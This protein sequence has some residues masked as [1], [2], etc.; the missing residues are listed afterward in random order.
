MKLVRYFTRIPKKIPEGCVAF[1]NFRP[2]HPERKPEENGF[3]LYFGRLEAGEKLGPPCDCGW[4]WKGG[5][6][7][8]EPS[9]IRNKVKYKPPPKADPKIRHTAYR[10]LHNLLLHNHTEYTSAAIEEE[11]GDDGGWLVRVSLVEPPQWADEYFDDFSSSYHCRLEISLGAA[12]ACVRTK[13]L[14]RSREVDHEQE[15]VSYKK[16]FK[17][18]PA[19]LR[20]QT[21]LTYPEKDVDPLAAT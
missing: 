16:L 13:V 2:G 9:G 15:E 14:K 8:Y 17:S 21:E 18:L 19:I 1:H 20:R 6:E 4:S 12:G 3:R 11:P 5:I 10:I 7:H